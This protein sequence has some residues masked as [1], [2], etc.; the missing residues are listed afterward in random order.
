[1]NSNSLIHH[2]EI[3]VSDLHKTN[4][5]WQLLLGNHLGYIVYQK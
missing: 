4:L 2:I 3:Y 5:F 1:M